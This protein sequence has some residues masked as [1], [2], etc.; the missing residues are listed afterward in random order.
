MPETSNPRCWDSH[1][2]SVKQQ[3]R[4]HIPNINGSISHLFKKISRP[5]QLDGQ[6][7]H[8]IFLTWHRHMLLLMFA[9]WLLI[10]FSTCPN[11]LPWS[12]EPWSTINGA[13]THPSLIPSSDPSCYCLTTRLLS[14]ASLFGFLYVN[15]DPK[16]HCARSLP[17]DQSTLCYYCFFIFF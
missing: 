2:A 12:D 16:E 4:S 11:D 10:R 8:S 14:F 5:C 17:T 15:P 3:K 7:G 13:W 9:L 1:Y 6:A